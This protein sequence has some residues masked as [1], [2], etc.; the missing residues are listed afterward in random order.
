M[1]RPGTSESI[2]LFEALK[3]H[4]SNYPLFVRNITQYPITIPFS[5]REDFKKW[6]S[7]PLQLGKSLR[8]L[9]SQL[10]NLRDFLTETPLS[11]NM[12]FRRLVESG[13]LQ[14]EGHICW[15]HEPEDCEVMRALKAKSQIT[16][17]QSDRRLAIEATRRNH[18]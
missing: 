10:I 15:R 7:H 14:T 13:A 9:P 11:T 1:E 8:I 18:V 2:H 5:F 12:T 3:N 17:V 16:T 6:K 4:G